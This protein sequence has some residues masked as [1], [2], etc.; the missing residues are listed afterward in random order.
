[1]NATKQ[2]FQPLVIVLLKTHGLGVNPHWL[3]LTTMSKK[4]H[5]Y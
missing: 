5:Y 2:V 4:T 1:M 3:G